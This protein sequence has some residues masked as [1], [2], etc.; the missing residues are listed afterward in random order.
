M[1]NPFLSVLIPA[2]N[3]A[4]YLPECLDS[5]LSQGESR[6]EIVVVDDGSTDGTGEVLA[7]YAAADPRI[8]LFPQEH[9]GV[10]VAH[11]RLLEEA[12]G[13]WL[14]FCDADDRVAPGAFSRLFKATA[15]EGLDAVCFGADVF[16]DS[17][18][19]ETRFSQFKNRYAFSHDFSAPRPGPDYV[20]D[21]VEANEWKPL[22]WSMVFRG[23]LARRNAIRFLPDNIHDDNI[24]ILELLLHA[25]QVVRIADRLYCRR[26]REGSIMTTYHPREDFACY[27]QNAL[28]ILELDGTSAFPPR[29]RQVLGTLAAYHF[30]YARTALQQDLPRSDNDWLKGKGPC[31]YAYAS[32]L[33]R[34][35]TEEEFQQ[36]NQ[37]IAKLDEKI[38]LL[39]K[40]VAQREQKIA[41]LSKQIARL[42]K[43]VEAKRTRIDTLESSWSF[44]LGKGLL[45]VPRFLLSFRHHE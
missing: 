31:E 10:S 7:R 26:L 28:R 21:C 5:I 8:R 4:R 39:G 42:Q 27:L 29:I 36:K 17:K 23:D 18:D 20:L 6:I 32:I 19:L 40:T 41:E 11:N 33:S 12:R 14:Y 13:E 15:A 9:R 35:R 34:T 38:A 24:F 2:Y 45:A 1:N 3:V 37:A 22:L 25:G 44:R 16:F 43:D 30:S